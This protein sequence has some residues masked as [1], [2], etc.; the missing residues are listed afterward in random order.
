MSLLP[1]RFRTLRWQINIILIT[2]TGIVAIAATLYV[3]YFIAQQL[4]EGMERKSTAVAT[5]LSGNLAAALEFEDKD[6]ALETMGALKLDPEFEYARVATTDGGE[7]ATLGEVPDYAKK[8]STDGTKMEVFL[9]DEKLHASKPI[10]RENARL[11]HLLIGYSLKTI[12]ERGFDILVSGILV[13]LLLILALSLYFAYAMNRTVILPITKMT[14]FVIKIGKGDLTRESILTHRKNE[15]VE[16][17]VMREALETATQSF[18]ENVESIQFA[19]K[20]FASIATHIQGASTALSSAAAQ[21]F[22]RVNDAFDTAKK[23]EA[24]GENAANSAKEISEVAETSAKISGKGLSVVNDSVGQFTNVRRQ[25]QTIV[26]VAEQLNAMV[27][28]IDEIVVSV[29]DVARQSQLLAVNASIEAAKA[30]EAGL[31]FGVVAKQVKD[32]AL[33]SNEA[34]GTV[35]KT[36]ENVKKNIKNISEV[37]EDGRTR[38]TQGMQSIENG[39]RVI[40]QLADMIH[41]TARAARKISDSTETQVVGLRAMS[42]SMF[43]VDDLSK[44]NLDTVKSLEKF[45]ESLNDKAREMERLVSKFQIERTEE[46]QD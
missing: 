13:C 5:L 1:S 28:E 32:L 25:V 45:G 16:I 17:K 7:F 37:S 23:M 18:R 29:A 34:T 40:Q 19:S 35:R 8:M 41:N 10:T 2:G 27:S 6:A 44:S 42:S 15:A 26:E 3:S 24:A 31:R 20:E 46:I 30:G 12:I 11:G 43:R 36:L 21:Q 14:E 38:A 39:G 22:D 33:Q 9:Q 4:R